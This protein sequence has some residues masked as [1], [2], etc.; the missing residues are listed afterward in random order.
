MELLTEIADDLGVH[1]Q[2]LYKLRERRADF[3]RP[4]KNV[5]RL[6]FYDGPEFK[7]WYRLAVEPHPNSALHVR[8]RHAL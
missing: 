6:R 7:M 3:P 2:S 4:I 8:E 1:V 5:G